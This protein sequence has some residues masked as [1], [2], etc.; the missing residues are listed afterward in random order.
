M[1]TK[2]LNF[3]NYLKQG[4]LFKQLRASFKQ[5]GACCCSVV[6]KQKQLI[7]TNRAKVLNIFSEFVLNIC[8][9]LTM[10]C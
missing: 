6:I 7:Q 8:S 10:D 9:K 4:C 5:A 3:L 2:F 1:K